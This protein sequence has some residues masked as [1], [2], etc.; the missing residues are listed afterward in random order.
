MSFIITESNS[1]FFNG[2]V[3]INKNYLVFP[4]NSSILTILF[5]FFLSL[6]VYGIFFIFPE[7]FLS[8][9]FD[10]VY[11]LEVAMLLGSSVSILVCIYWFRFWK[12]NFNHHNVINIT[13]NKSEQYVEFTRDVGER[14]NLDSYKIHF[15]FLINL[16]ISGV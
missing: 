3:T 15:D 16:I 12:V 1:S 9:I 14:K 5:P 11:T 8:S 2:N 4:V 6:I 10:S 7:S 13:I